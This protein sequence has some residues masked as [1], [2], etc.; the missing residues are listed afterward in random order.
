MFFLPGFIIF[1]HSANADDLPFNMPTG[2]DT[3]IKPQTTEGLFGDVEGQLSSISA[4]VYDWGIIIITILF[5]GGAF[6]MLLSV[7]FKN[8]QW[9]KSGQ[10]LMGFSFITLLVLRGAPIIVLSVRDPGNDI[11][12][13]LQGVMSYLSAAVIYAGIIAIVMSFLFRF[14]YSLIE[15]PEFHRWSRHLRSIALLMILFSFIVPLFF[16]T[17]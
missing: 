9:Q 16:P 1:S 12:Y 3:T 10:L 13:L 2:E 14:G 7:L 5:V 15:H 6:V 17:I 8:G 4:A 11:G